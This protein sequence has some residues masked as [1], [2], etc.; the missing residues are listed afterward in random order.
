MTDFLIIGNKNSIACKDVWPHIQRGEVCF[1]VTKPGHYMTPDGE[2][3]KKLDGLTRWYTTMQV[4]NQKPP[5]VHSCTYNPVTYRQYDN[6]DAVEVG[7]ISDIPD[8]NGIMGVPLT[9]LDY[10][11]EEY[12]ILSIACGNSWKNYPE[13]LK[14][15]GFDQTQKYGGGLGAPLL[16]GKPKYVRIIIRRR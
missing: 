7:K 10:S 2:Q 16:D 8:Y 15:L 9:V 6:Y 13:T 11:L 14:E 5:I 12:D 3:T 4:D 1:G